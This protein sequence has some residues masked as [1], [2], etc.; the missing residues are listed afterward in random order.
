MDQVEQAVLMGHQEQAVALERPVLQEV[1]ELK[2]V[3]V[4]AV[5]MVLMEL[6]RLALSIII[7]QH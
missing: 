7:V 4:Q 5:L 3:Q 2:V 6:I 1:R